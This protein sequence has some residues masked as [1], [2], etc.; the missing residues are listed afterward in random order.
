MM[1]DLIDL[2]KTRDRHGV[3]REMLTRRGVNYNVLPYAHGVNYE[4]VF[5]ERPRRVIGAHHDIVTRGDGAND[6][7]ASVVELV[8][9]A[10]KLTRERFIG[11]LRIVFFDNEELLCRGAF[12]EMGSAEYAK[13]TTNETE[14]AIVLDVCGAG[15]VLVVSGLWHRAKLSAP[16]ENWLMKKENTV[17]ITTPPSDD[18]SF[19]RYGVPVTLMCTLPE[20]ESA[21]GDRRLTWER[22]HTAG[23]S[24]ETVN[25]DTMELVVSTLYDYVTGRA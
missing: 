2:C 14:E 6:N 22:L 25:E 19:L 10:T 13:H 3:L 15:D 16:F 5:G 12:D 20:T 11:D 9:L 18:V 21:P 4:V 17:R 7:T 23:D 1:L 24:I 8:E